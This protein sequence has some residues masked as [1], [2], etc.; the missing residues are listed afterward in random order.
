MFLAWGAEQHGK[1]WDVPKDNKASLRSRRTVEPD[2]GEVIKRSTEKTV[3]RAILSVLFTL[4][5]VAF[6]GVGIYLGI[7]LLTG[8]SSKDTPLG[9][10]ITGLVFGCGGIIFFGGGA[11]FTAGYV[12][13]LM[14]GERLILGARYFQS[15]SKTDEV[16]FQIPWDNIRS[17]TQCSEVTNGIARNWI[18]INVHDSERTDTI[19]DPESA[20]YDPDWR[21]DLAVYDEYLVSHKELFGLLRDTLEDQQFPAPT[22]GGAEPRP[23][24]RGS[25]AKRTRPKTS[26]WLP[27]LVLGG[28]G[29]GLTLILAACGVAYWLLKPSPPQAQATP[30]AV[31][32][33]KQPAT[34]PTKPPE[35]QGPASWPPAAP[36]LDAAPVAAGNFPGL[37]AYWPLD[38]GQGN[39][40]ANAAGGAPAPVV[41]GQWIDGVRGKALLLDGK[42]DYVNLGDASQLNFGDRAP[43]SLS[44]WIATKQG[45][46]VFL[47]MRHSA[48]GA[49]VLCLEVSGPALQVT[50]RSDGPEIGEV[51]GNGGKVND[52]R[53]HHVALVRGDD[54]VVGGLPRR[55]PT[56][57][58]QGSARRWGLDHQPAGA[59]F[60][61]LP[62]HQGRL[63]QPVLQRGGGRVGDF[64]P[65][66]D[67][68][69]DQGA[70]RPAL[71]G[72]ASGAA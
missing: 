13:K 33:A 52:G 35:E 61:A 72:A 69:G 4:A 22:P 37:V 38:E 39:Q 14:V 27:V 24:K 46:G 6:L 63:R 47:A 9:Q 70:G 66:A 41:G 8:G 26:P 62:G 7:K 45:G 15:L 68:A 60:G 51:R 31:A 54:G 20:I 5:G 30:P 57:P 58:A 65:G 23:R 32:G 25:A 48:D 12:R 10:L 1:G 42:G 3:V 53:W 56:H 34:A 50:I 44:V 29:A 49:S 2:V 59:G 64:W 40:A 18:A 16:N 67:R 36:K 55:Q 17:L 43:F 71:T 28:L 21:T 19:L 11:L